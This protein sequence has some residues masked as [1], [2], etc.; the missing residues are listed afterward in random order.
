MKDFPKGEQR[1]STELLSPLFQTQSW[2]VHPHTGAD[3]NE[4]TQSFRTLRIGAGTYSTGPGKG[5]EGGPAGTTESRVSF[6]FFYYSGPKTFWKGG[7]LH[8]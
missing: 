1:V 3:S 8:V 7:A 5:G 2:L 6:T 4:E